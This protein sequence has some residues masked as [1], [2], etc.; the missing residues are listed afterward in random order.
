MKNLMLAQS[1]GP[2]AAINATLAG[3]VQQAQI[4]GKIG[5]VYG[6]IYGIKGL[7]EGCVIELSSRLDNTSRLEQLCMT[8]AAALGSCRIKLKSSQEDETLYQFIIATLRK[9]EIGYFVYIG[10][11]D[12]MDTVLL[13]SEYL[14]SKGID[15][16][17]VIGAPKTIDNDLC[18]IDH[19]PGYG[20][21][22]KYIGTVFSELACDCAT[23]DSPSVTIVEVMG[24]NAGWLTASSV[25]AR[26]NGLSAPHLIYLPEVPFDTQKFLCDVKKKIELDTTVLVAVSE[27]I[28]NKSGNYVAKTN[29]PNAVDMFGHQSLSGVGKYLEEIVSEEI[30]CKVRSIQLNV[31]QRAA[32]HLVSAVDIEEAKQLGAMAVCS[33]VDGQSGMMASIV[34]R[35]FNTSYSI[36]YKMVEIEKVANKEKK[37]PVEWISADGN[38]LN[39]EFLDYVMPLVQGERSI[40]LKN[41]IPDYIKFYW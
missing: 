28:K 21:A 35:E 5:R 26:Q 36:Y 10:G 3:A 27:G 31:L 4:C 40:P 37:V 29:L 13:L 32:S 2:T 41:G 39:K 19:T 30:G 7:I 33:A 38:N 6:S 18:E 25:L 1:G 34:R 12:S 14:K 24:R 11:N 23:Y 9:Y 20:S 15:D 22:A 16:I 8:P 17:S